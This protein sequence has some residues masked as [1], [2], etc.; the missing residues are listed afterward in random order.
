MSMSSHEAL[1]VQ[2]SV[3]P[4][5]PAFLPPLAKQ[6][7][8]AK[9]LDLAKWLVSPAHP[10]TARVTV[11]RFW[12]QFFGVGLVKSVG[13]FG[14]Q[15][16]PPSHPEL[17]DWLAVAFRDGGWDVKALVRQMVTSATFRQSSRVSQELV[18]RDPE[19][20][21]YARGPRFRLDAE[22]V[23]DNSLA[24]AGLINLKMGGVGAKSYQPANIWEPVGFAGSNT[25]NYVQDKGDALYRRSIYAFFKR[26]APPPFMSNF[27]APNREQSCTMRE[28]S[29]TPMQALQLMN[30]TQHVEAA[31]AL[32]QRMLVEGGNEPSARIIF[33]FRTVLSR[34]PE[35]QEMTVLQQ[36]LAAHLI[37]YQQDAESAK[38][39]IATGDSKAK[40]E[41]DPVQF[42]AHTL[43]ASTLLNLDET[44][45]RN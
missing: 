45:S 10:L 5:T 17:L 1:V 36:Q 37:R 20:L 3:V 13:D 14:S 19:N 15:G 43:I 12:Q 41:I 2:S 40:P 34:K 44:V 42:A 38:K 33:A 11:N 9:R 4:A 39:L 26:T 25:R 22:Q 30:D 8:R 29:N 18:A 28:R 23:R 32:A 16:T 7:E 24:V 31:R 6:G 21:L 27:D 35:P